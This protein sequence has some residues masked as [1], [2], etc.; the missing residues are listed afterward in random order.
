MLNI[1][2]MSDMFSIS[3]EDGYYPYCE[4]WTGP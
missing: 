1:S 4:I 2:P 3:E